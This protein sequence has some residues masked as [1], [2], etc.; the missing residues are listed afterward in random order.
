MEGIV[1]FDL[2]QIQKFRMN[3]NLKYMQKK[4]E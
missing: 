3:L 2:P 4:K 1:Y